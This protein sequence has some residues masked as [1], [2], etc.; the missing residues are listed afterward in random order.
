MQQ[1]K[2]IIEWS[3]GNSFSKSSSS[4]DSSLWEFDKFGNTINGQKTGA[5]QNAYYTRMPHDK[6]NSGKWT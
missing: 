3:G 4:T 2:D 1:I 6:R 5:T